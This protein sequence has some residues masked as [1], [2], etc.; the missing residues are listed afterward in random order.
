M[1]FRLSRDRWLG[2]GWGLARG[3]CVEEPAI[4]DAKPVTHATETFLGAP[5]AL[6]RL[7]VGLEVA[8]D[9]VGGAPF[10]RP[11]GFFSGFAFRQFPFVEDTAF[12]VGVAQLGDGD[13]VEG[14]VEHPVT[15][16]VEPVPFLLARGGFDWGGAVVGG[17]VM[18]G[19]EP[20]HITRVADQ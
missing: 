7:L 8:V 5:R 14:V 1:V 9:D 15:P 3:G 13:E 18:A 12:G 2:V 19:R 20:G 11:D 4:Q 10:Q 6:T 17:V 16:R